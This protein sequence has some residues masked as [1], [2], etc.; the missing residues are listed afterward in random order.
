LPEG[1]DTFVASWLRRTLAAWR[2]ILYAI[3]TPRRLVF[4]S[5]IAGHQPKA[6]AV[7][8]LAIV[9]LILCL[10]QLGAKTNRATRGVVGQGPALA[11]GCRTVA[12]KGFSAIL[13]IALEDLHAKRVGV[14]QE[15]ARSV[16]VPALRRAVLGIVI[17]YA[18]TI[19]IA[20]G[21]HRR[22]GGGIGAAKD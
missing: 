7:L 6:Q 2:P 21:S 16:R 19:R 20:I 17:D 3:V 18:S 5:S 13:T 1:P 4:Q 14:I 11:Y 22:A 15:F 10:Y 12:Y 9:D 8:P